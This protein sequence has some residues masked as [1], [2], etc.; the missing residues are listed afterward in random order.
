MSLLIH[1][2]WPE[3]WWTS[4]GAG[5]GGQ[6]QRSKHH[7]CRSFPGALPGGRE[8]RPESFSQRP[9]CPQ[10]QPDTQGR[11]SQGF[12]HLLSFNVKISVSGALK[13][14]ISDLLFGS[15]HCFQVLQHRRSV[16]AVGEADPIKRHQAFAGPVRRRTLIGFPGCFTLQ[17]SVLHHSL[18]WSHL[19]TVELVKFPMRSN[20]N[21]ALYR[22]VCM[23]WVKDYLLSVKILGFCQ[24]MLL[25]HFVW[26]I[27]KMNLK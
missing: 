10:Y 21:S 24:W 22:N 8:P 5:H 2:Y 16:S 20:Q 12:I 15:E 9:S 17:F 4:S 14:K 7:R 1:K 11:R 3:E 13:T 18:H 25:I 27:L 26:E 19:K 6:S 23:C